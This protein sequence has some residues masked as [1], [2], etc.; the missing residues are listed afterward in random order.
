MSDPTAEYASMGG[1]ASTA[2]VS[3]THLT[4]QHYSSNHYQRLLAGLEGKLDWLS[5]K[6]AA[7]PDFRDFNPNAPIS[8]LHTTRFY[9]EAAV[10]A[11]L[12]QDLSLIH[13]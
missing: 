13:I 3:Y 4:D 9:A 12:P 6:L 8:D 1:A 10:T 11:T 2:A 7:G 5:V